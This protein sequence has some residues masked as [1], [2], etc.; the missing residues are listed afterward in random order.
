M[1]NLPNS[2]LLKLETLCDE[3]FPIWHRSHT[4]SYSNLLQ[5]FANPPHLHVI[6]QYSRHQTGFASKEFE[7]SSG[8]LEAPHNSAHLAQTVRFPKIKQN[9]VKHCV[10]QYVGVKN[11]LKVHICDTVRYSLWYIPSTINI[12]KVEN[13]SLSFKDSTFCAVLLELCLETWRVP[14]VVRDCDHTQSLKSKQY[15]RRCQ[16]KLQTHMSSKNKPV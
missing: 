10:F 15:L 1:S 5:M 14:S 3:E 4:H 8:S 13:F 12:L 11:I 16:I 6:S 9:N 2:P 7:I